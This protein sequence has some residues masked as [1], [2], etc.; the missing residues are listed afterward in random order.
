MWNRN[1]YVVLVRKPLGKRSHG[2]PR[3]DGMTILKYVLKKQDQ[4]MWPGLVQLR[5]GTDSD[6]DLFT[7]HKSCQDYNS[8]Y[9]YRNSHINVVTLVKHKRIQI[10]VTIQHRLS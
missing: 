9:G 10:I 1:N 5:I 4:K 7:F 2:R 6:S 8:P 3:T